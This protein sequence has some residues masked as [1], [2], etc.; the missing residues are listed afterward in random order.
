MKGHFRDVMQL[1]KG[2]AKISSIAD[3]LPEVWQFIQ[4]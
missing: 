3:V 4:N 1:V 2:G